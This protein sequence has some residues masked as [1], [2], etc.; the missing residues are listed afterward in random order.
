MGEH[1]APGLVASSEVAQV[2]HV[3]VEAW[4]GQAMGRCPSCFGPLVTG[5]ALRENRQKL[6]DT[7]RT[8]ANSRRLGETDGRQPAE[9]NGTDGDWWK[10]AETGGNWWEHLVESGP[11]TER[12]GH[13]QLV[14]TDRAPAS[15]NQI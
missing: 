9:T 7:S 14:E 6:V 15:N 8:D 12:E 2:A 13:E 11:T 4:V 1:P 5:R 10:L 3:D